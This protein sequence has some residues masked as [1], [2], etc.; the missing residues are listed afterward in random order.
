MRKPG[1]ES[2]PRGGTP[3]PDFAGLEEIEPEPWPTEFTDYNT[4]NV[5]FG[6]WRT[7]L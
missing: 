4:H 7:F 6:S 2:P 3:P 5:S 1:E